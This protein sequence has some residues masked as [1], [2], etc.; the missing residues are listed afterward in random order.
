MFGLFR[1]TITCLDKITVPK[2]CMAMVRPHLEYGNVIWHPRFKLNKAYIE[3][4]QRRATKPIPTLRHEPYDARL[5]CLKLSSLDYRRRRGDM[6]QVFRIL[7]GLNRLDPQLF[8]SSRNK[9][10]PEVIAKRYTKT[11][12]D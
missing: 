11:I 5:R 8:S 10:A 2:I 6:L 9:H 3:K 12:A 4:V 1:A 7:N